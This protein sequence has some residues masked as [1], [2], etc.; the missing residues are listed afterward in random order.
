LGRLLPRVELNGHY[1]VHSFNLDELRL[2]IPEPEARSSLPPSYPVL[3]YR[4]LPGDGLPAWVNGFN[5]I[6]VF[7]RLAGIDDRESAFA[8]FMSIDGFDALYPDAVERVDALTASTVTDLDFSFLCSFEVEAEPRVEWSQVVLPAFRPRHFAVLLEALFVFQLCKRTELAINALPAR[9]AAGESADMLAA[10]TESLFNLERPGEYNVSETD[11]AE[12]QLYYEA[13]GIGEYIERL[14]ERFNQATA[15]YA[16]VWEQAQSERTQLVNI[17]LGTLALLAL[18]QADQ[19]LAAMFGIKQRLLDWII[20]VLALL[21]VTW[22][23]W[24]YAIVPA[25]RRRRQRREAEAALRRL[26]LRP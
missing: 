23:V 8:R 3:Q 6:L 9:R 14:R 4:R 22:A 15:N 7:Q 18:L 19:T 13:W 2:A 10:Y 21:A 1:F 17:L 26:H 11:A 25:L 16:F 20:V 12:M 24:R 5:A